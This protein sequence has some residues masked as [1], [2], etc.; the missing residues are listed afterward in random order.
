[1]EQLYQNGL[2]LFQGGKMEDLDNSWILLNNEVDCRNNDDN[3]PATLGLKNMRGVFILVGLGIIGGLGLIVIEII[4]KK[5]Q[6]RKANHVVAAKTAVKKWRG[7]I[8]VSQSSRQLFW[9]KYRW[10]KST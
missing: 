3:S 4:Y 8:E 9:C 1:M 10:Y 2:V 5:H 6:L 7:T